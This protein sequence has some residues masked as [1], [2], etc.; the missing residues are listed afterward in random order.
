M[1]SSIG[2]KAVYLP[3][4]TISLLR[5]PHLPP[6]IAQFIVPLK[7]NKFDLRDYLNHVYNVETLNVRSFIT[8]QKIQRHKPGYHSTRYCRPKSIKK[9]TVELMKPFV[10]PKEPQDLRPWDNVLWKALETQRE[11]QSKTQGPFSYKEPN[12]ARADIG[13]LAKVLEEQRLDVEQGLSV[14]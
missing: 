11:Q 13:K 2:M 12:P 3:S 6:T 4:F 5:T 8:Q 7:V 1:L 9:M 10:Y 14:R